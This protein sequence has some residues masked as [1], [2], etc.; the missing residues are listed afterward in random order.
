[1]AQKSEAAY[2]V[3]YFYVWHKCLNI[4][5]TTVSGVQTLTGKNERICSWPLNRHKCSPD[6]CIDS[7]HKY[8]N[9]KTNKALQTENLAD[10]H[11]Y[12]KSLAL[13]PKFRC[14]DIRRNNCTLFFHVVFKCLCL[15]GT[16][17]PNLSQATNIPATVYKHVYSSFEAYKLFHLTNKMCKPCNDLAGKQHVLIK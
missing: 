15:I 2:L 16:H 8:R 10:S 13:H 12:H 4:I 5:A 7:T 11:K 17:N 6:R 3:W 1:M 9:I 14:S